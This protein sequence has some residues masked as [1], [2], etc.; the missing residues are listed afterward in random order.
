MAIAMINQEHNPTS[1]RHRSH[2]PSISNERMFN[3]RRYMKIHIAPMDQHKTTFTCPFGTFAYTRMSFGLYNAPNTFQRYMMSIFLDLLEDCME[4]FIDDFTVYVESFEAFLDNLS[5]ILRRCIDSN[6]V[7]NIEKCNFMVTEGIVL[8][9]LVLVRGIEVDK[10]KI[11]VISSL[12]N[13]VSM[14]E[15]RS[16]LDH[17]ASIQAAIEG[18]GLCVRS[19]LCG[20][21]S[22]AEE[23]THVHFHPPSTKL[24]AVVRVDVRHVQ[25]CTRSCPRTMSLQAAARDCLRISSNGPSLGKL[26]NHRKKAF[27]NHNFRSYLLG[28]KIIVFSNHAALKYLLKKSDMLLLQEFNVEIKDKKGAK[29]A[30]ADHL[31]RLEREVN[32]MPIQDEFLDEQLL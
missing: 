1:S 22:G 30:I 8:G 18:H 21:I 25:L 6:L 23:K 16:F 11:D 4:V 3:D 13:P 19:A 20:H 32:P 2:K 27:G 14:Q 7:L 10:A 29:N 9:H 17:V 28:T 15:V 12:S 24:G 31:S 26:F 5:R